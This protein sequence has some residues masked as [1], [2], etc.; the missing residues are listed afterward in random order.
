[1]PIDPNADQPLPGLEPAPAHVSDV[2]AGLR[3]TFAALAAE[4]RL[5]EIDAGRL[6]IA[7]AGARVMAGK[8]RS[9]KT[10]TWNAD[11]RL[12]AEIL[13]R[14][15]GGEAA[16]GFEE[17]IQQAMEAWAQMGADEFS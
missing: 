12:V 15:T 9:G 3:R 1:M 13:D 14:L 5:S 2:E 16:E 6:A 11:A 4:E 7:L 10:S 17:R 8:E